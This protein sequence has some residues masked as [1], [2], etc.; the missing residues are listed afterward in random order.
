LRNESGGNPRA[1]EPTS[2]AGGLF[3]FLPS[4]WHSLGYSGLAQNA[5]ISTQIQAAGALYL[6]SGYTPWV[7]DGC[8]R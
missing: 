7:S 6:R 2:G 3:Q 8:V 5:A 4:T 1:V